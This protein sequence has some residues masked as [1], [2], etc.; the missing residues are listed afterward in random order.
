MGDG[1][2]EEEKHQG[3]TRR[4]GDQQELGVEFVALRFEYPYRT[5]SL[6]SLSR[7]SLSLPVTSQH[8]VPQDLYITRGAI[9]RAFACSRLAAERTHTCVRHGAA[10]HSTAYRRTH[11]HITLLSLFFYPV[12][13]SLYRNHKNSRNT[14]HEHEKGTKRRRTHN[15]VDP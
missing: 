9:L 11:H 7:A 1:T 13:P 14:C 10:Q 12:V 5:Y 15:I 8:Q 3:R 4:E 6:D 2:K